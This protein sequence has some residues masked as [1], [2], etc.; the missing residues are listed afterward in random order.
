MD[1]TVLVIFQIAKP[2][3][4]ILF[5]WPLIYKAFRLMMTDTLSIPDLHLSVQ[6]LELCIR[7]S[8]LGYCICSIFTP[9]P[10]PFIKLDNL[11][12]ISFDEQTRKLWIGRIEAYIRLLSDLNEKQLPPRK[13]A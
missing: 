12:L 1:E 8:S 9:R 2:F 10:N 3:L 13:L 5:I 6:T 7:F 11:L 4:V